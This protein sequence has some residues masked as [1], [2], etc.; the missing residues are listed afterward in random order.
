MAWWEV[1]DIPKEK[2][3]IEIALSLPEEIECSI[4]E[5]IFDE[6]SIA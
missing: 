4:H 6:L 3:G 1:T 5:K 2:Q